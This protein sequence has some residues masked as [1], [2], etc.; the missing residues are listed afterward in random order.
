MGL[1]D[2]RRCVAFLA[3]GLC[4]FMASAGA[5]SPAE[6]ARGERAREVLGLL[7]AEVL[8][9]DLPAAAAGRPFATA[10]RVAGREERLELVPADVRAP[11]YRLL[12]QR[13]DG[14]FAVPPPRPAATFRGT[15]EAH[16]GSRVAATLDSDGL[17]ARIVLPDGTELY[18][19]PVSGSVPG[20]ARR[21]HV[22]Y[23][24]HDVVAPGVPCAEPLTAPAGSG[25]STPTGTATAPPVAASAGAG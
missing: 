9:L 21:E 7:D 3:G 19:E 14:S 22:L 4:L 11:G 18:V 17:H 13:D 25:A 6:R 23:A 15:L 20:A 5:Q 16:P 12:V 8:G 24:R 2:T 10:L 1:E